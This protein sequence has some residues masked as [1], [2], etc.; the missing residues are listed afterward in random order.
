MNLK[1]FI[2]RHP[3]LSYFILAYLIAWGGI[4]LIVRTFA[5]PGELPRWA[6]RLAHQL[7][8]PGALVQPFVGHPATSVP[9]CRSVASYVYACIL[10]MMHL[11]SRLLIWTQYM[12]QA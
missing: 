11:T 8:T 4:L 12:R 7:C 6:G 9:D 2:E 1:N 10:A 5:A 3:V